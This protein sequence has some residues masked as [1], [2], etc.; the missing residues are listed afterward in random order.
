MDCSPP[1][2]SVQGTL[3]ARILGGLPFPTL[4]N[5]PNPGIEP[6]ALQSDS[7]P[8]ELPGS[9]TLTEITAVIVVCI[10]NYKIL[11]LFNV[12]DYGFFKSV[13]F[14]VTLLPYIPITCPLSPVPH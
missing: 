13:F 7:L 12:T 2:S 10:C 6:L 11:F 5:L 4:G 14:H 9:P 8:S 3:Q 1:G